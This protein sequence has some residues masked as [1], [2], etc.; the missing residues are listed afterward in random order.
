MKAYGSPLGVAIHRPESMKSRER[1][2]FPCGA[3]A[4]FPA[5]P[6]EEA[7][8]VRVVGRTE[9]EA[10]A[11]ELDAYAYGIAHELRAPIRAIERAGKS[12][13]AENGS[14]LEPGCRSKLRKM[15]KD[16]SHLASLSNALLELDRIGR[17]P[18]KPER[19]DLRV[20]VKPVMIKLMNSR[21]PREAEFRVPEGV[22][23]FGDRD[24]L[25]IAF[26]HVLENAWRFTAGNA[27]TVIEIGTAA[28]GVESSLFVRDNGI[29]FDPA[30]KDRL[31]IPFGTLH[32]RTNGSGYG[33]G[34][35][36]V[37]RIIRRHG[38][39]VWADGRPGQGATFFF[40]LPGIRSA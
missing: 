1:I 3:A 27:R 15:F 4:G 8:S 29:G 5:L 19:I 22:G 31:F 6:D 9:S 16:V 37:R 36:V 25:R 23:I 34:L 10:L 40:A 26:G 17:V 12:L 39:R 38:G 32:P 2:P 28:T 30:V 35:A 13:L 20:L 21:P 18:L 11:K 14:C 7:V 24:L 33:I